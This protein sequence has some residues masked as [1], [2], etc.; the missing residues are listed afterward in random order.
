VQNLL[1]DPI[2]QSVGVPFVVALV[3][4]VLIRG[5]LGARLGRLLAVAAAALGFLACYANL[6]GV[7]A[8]PPPASG[9]KIFYL[10][11]VGLLA[12]AAIDLSGSGR[13]AGHAFSFIFPIGAFAWIA[14]RAI[15]GGPSGDVILTLLALLA[16]SVLVFWR[17]AATARSDD[18]EMDPRHALSP[19]IM[20]FVA[21]LGAGL[22]ALFGASASLSQ[23]SIGLALATAGFLL[24]AFVGY[25]RGGEPFGFG[26]TGAF[27]AAGALIVLIAVMALFAD[28]VSKWA[29]L[30]VALV[31]A[32]DLIARRVALKGAA[33]R[34][35]NP[36]LYG[37]IVAVPAAAGAIVAALSSDPGGGY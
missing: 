17:V 5:A 31:F 25:L 23:L 34:V 30:L 26:G 8:F 7:P 35:L 33:G 11:V 20:V 36:I 6:L 10:V 13:K 27:G 12:G 4:A 15:S 2:V 1:A 37:A 9:A 28:E 22:A 14:W 16:G 24:P 32:A 3:L 29:L 21:A 19:A 18:V